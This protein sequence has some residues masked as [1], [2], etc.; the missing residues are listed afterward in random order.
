M[1][2]VFHINLQKPVWHSG[3]STHLFKPVFV[4]SALDFSSFTDMQ[5]PV[6]SPV[7]RIC[8]VLFP[9][10][11]VMSGIKTTYWSQ[12]FKLMKQSKCSIIRN[13]SFLDSRQKF[14]CLVKPN[15]PYVQAF[16]VFLCRYIFTHILSVMA[17][18]NFGYKFYKM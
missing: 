17:S 9:Y 1:T 15:H 6:I 12:S 16:V 14:N 7:L 13:R 4:G 8:N 2:G 18:L 3:L 10:D 11:L 5:C